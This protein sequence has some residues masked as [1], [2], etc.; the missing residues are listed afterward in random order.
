MCPPSRHVARPS[1]SGEPIGL[2][3]VL[4]VALVSCLA[5]RLREP[6]KQVI[7]SLRLGNHLVDDHVDEIEQ[8]NGR[9]YLDTKLFLRGDPLS[10][11]SVPLSL[12]HI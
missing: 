3:L 2:A 7:H 4:R 6:A 12:I 10:L 9:G 8:C 11:S 1:D 5:N